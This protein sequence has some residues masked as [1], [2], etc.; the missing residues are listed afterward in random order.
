M[1]KK[2]KGGSEAPAPSTAFKILLLSRTFESAARTLPS[3][4]CQGEANRGGTLEEAVLLASFPT[5]P[6]LF[7]KM[8]IWCS[9]HVWLQ[10]TIG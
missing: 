7:G 1:E 9:V 10:L 3:C 2:P 4:I 5:L 8:R 6:F